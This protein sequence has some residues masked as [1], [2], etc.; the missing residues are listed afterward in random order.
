MLKTHLR[1]LAIFSLQRLHP[2]DPA[3]Q[4]LPLCT[5]LGSGSVLVEPVSGRLVG[6]VTCGPF[7]RSPE[8]CL[9]GLSV[10]R[11]P[12]RFVLIVLLLLLLRAKPPKPG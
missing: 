10:L 9:V 1:R 7:V 4:L 11:Q 2:R 5:M 12:L 8:M 6:T 3:L